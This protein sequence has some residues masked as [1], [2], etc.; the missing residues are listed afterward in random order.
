MEITASQVKELREKTG[1]GMMDAKKAL[2]EAGGDM[3][4]ASELL[5]QKGIAT[6]EKKSGRTAAEG[7]VAS[8][9]APDRK[10][11]TLV[12]VNCETDFV[13][14]GE[15]F[16]KMVNE[17]A[18]QIL[19]Q[20]ANDVDSLLKQDSIAMPGNSM[21]QYVTENI[22]TIKENL[23]IRRFVRYEVQ[24]NGAVHSYIHTGGR[25][26]V[27]VELKCGKQES[28]ESPVFQ[29]LVK[30]LAMQIASASP[31][32][33]S[34]SDIDSAVIDEETRVEMGKEDLA[35]KP[36]D[37]RRKIVEGRVSK[38]L[39]QRCLIE[40]PFVKDP[41]QSVDDVIKARATEIGD[42]SVEV[43]RFT[44]YALGEGIEKKESNFAEEVAAAARV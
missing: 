35:S 12:E 39:G 2:V 14:K 21:Q 23:S 3:E 28:V 29:Q 33:V 40:Q 9:I 11:G 10:S 42:T 43:V 27:L 17:V 38:I 16:Q 18:Q 41:S 36:E 19:A 20:K 22:A 24:G 34:R 6:A 30:D 7:Q 44:R 32:F 15:A 13:A 4:K 5:R 31:D 1:A 8:L 26:G 25:V 37:I